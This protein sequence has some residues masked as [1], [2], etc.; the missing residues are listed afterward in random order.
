MVYSNLDLCK[1][2]VLVGGATEAVSEVRGDRDVVNKRGRN[3]YFD[4]CD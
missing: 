3:V 2:M 4:I 1:L